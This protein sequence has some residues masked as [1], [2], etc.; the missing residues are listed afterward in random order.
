MADN[1]ICDILGIEKP[2]IQAPL[3][4]LTDAKLVASVSQAGDWEPWGPMPVLRMR[5]V[6][7]HLKTEQKKCVPKSLIQNRSQTCRLPS[8]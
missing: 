6:L 8:I 1:R 2:V 5:Q 4:W 3:S 7:H